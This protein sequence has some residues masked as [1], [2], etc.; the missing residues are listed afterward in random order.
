MISGLTLFKVRPVMS[1][2]GS[3]DGF[4]LECSFFFHSDKE[5]IERLIQ[6]GHKPHIVDYEPQDNHF[7]KS[8]RKVVIFNKPMWLKDPS[9]CMQSDLSASARIS[10]GHGV[11]TVSLNSASDGWNFNESDVIAAR[12]LETKYGEQPVLLANISNPRAKCRY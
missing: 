11:V 4:S 1:T 2:G 9:G 5:L 3:A 8:W 12:D 10:I 7:W 6:L